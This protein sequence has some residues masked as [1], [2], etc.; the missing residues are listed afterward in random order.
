MS[1]VY[2]TWIGDVLLQSNTQACRVEVRFLVGIRRSGSG[3]AGPFG[4]LLPSYE[5]I[6]IIPPFL[7]LSVCCSESRDSR[8]Y[9]YVV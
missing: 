9:G 4:A 1:I 7:P 5:S 3:D 8:Q 2:G 6:M